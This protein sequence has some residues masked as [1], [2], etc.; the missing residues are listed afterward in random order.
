MNDEGMM[1]WVV[2]R[3]TAEGG[4]DARVWQ[5]PCVGTASRATINWPSETVPEDKTQTRCFQYVPRLNSLLWAIISVP[6]L[7]ALAPWLCLNLRCP[8]TRRLQQELDRL[9]SHVPLL[10]FYRPGTSSVQTGPQ[11]LVCGSWT[12]PLRRLE[13]TQ[14]IH[15]GV[16]G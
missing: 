1:E 11:E 15:V 2:S 4:W 12:P 8:S 5:Q 7:P 3:R 16:R 6:P 9:S 10:S 14:C 13:V